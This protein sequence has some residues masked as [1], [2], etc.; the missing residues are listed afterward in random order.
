MEAELPKMGEYGGGG[1]QKDKVARKETPT[2]SEIKGDAR[3][4]V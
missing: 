2:D 3:T 4:V 1:F